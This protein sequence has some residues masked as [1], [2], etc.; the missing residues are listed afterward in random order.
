MLAQALIDPPSSVDVQ[1]AACAVEDAC[2][3]I[4]VRSSLEAALAALS[5]SEQATGVVLGENGAVVGV[6]TRESVLRAIRTGS[7]ADS[8]AESIDTDHGQ[9]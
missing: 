1:T 7:E 4:D 9:R 2:V 6:V 3:I 8:S 5:G